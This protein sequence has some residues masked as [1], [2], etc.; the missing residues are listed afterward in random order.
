MLALF[1]LQS[2]PNPSMKE[3]KSSI[4]SLFLL[5]R[6]VTVL[7]EIKFLHAIVQMGVLRFKVFILINRTV[8]W[9]MLTPSESTW[10]SWQCIDSLPG[11]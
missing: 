1:L 11:F 3:Q 10:L 4:H 2:Q 6:K 7:M 8:Q 5:L 9:H